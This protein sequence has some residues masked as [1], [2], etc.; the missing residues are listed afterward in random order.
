MAKPI[1]S[2][3]GAVALI[4]E[5]DTEAVDGSGDGIVEPY[6]LMAPLGRRFRHTGSPR[7]LKVVHASCIGDRASRGLSHLAVEGLCK[8][9]ISAH[10]GQAGDMA[11]LAAASEVEANNFCQGV[12]TGA[13]GF[14]NISQ[15]AKTVLFCATLTAGGLEVKIQDGSIQIV[16]EGSYRQFGE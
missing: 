2:A 16:K 15:N 11:A 12:I 3:D 5:G 4:R 6:A 7:R 8:R 13:G 10:F 1:L 9:V 14:L